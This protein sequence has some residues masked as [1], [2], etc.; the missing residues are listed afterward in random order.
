MSQ[1]RPAK[2]RV[3]VSVGESVRI[4]R[5]LQGLS[6]TQLA[7]RTGIPQATLS[8][9]ENDR[10]RLGVERAKVLAKALRCH[11]AVLVFPGWES[12]LESAA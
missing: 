5:E 3:D 11:P 2:K 8:A 9:I 6:Q 1:F 7:Q 10:V 4:I 12:Q